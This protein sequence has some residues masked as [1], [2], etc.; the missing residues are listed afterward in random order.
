M[1]NKIACLINVRDRPTEL[2]LLL[3]SIRTQTIKDIDIFILDDCSGTPLSNYHFFNC[4][5]TRLKLDGYGIYLKRT[6]FQHGVSRARQAIVDYALSKGDYDYLLR[7]DDDVILE[8]DY[9]ERLLKVI[10]AGY[11]I[12]SGVTIPM[13]GPVFKRDPK[14]LNEIVNRVILDKDGNYIMNGD[15]CGYGYTDSII[16]PAHHFRSCALIKKEVHDK[17]KYYPTRLSKHGFREEQIFSYNALMSG[18][19]IGVDTGAI[20]YHQMTQSGGERFPDQRDLSMFNQNILIEFT[21]EHKDKLNKIFTHDNMPSKLALM[22]E[23]NLR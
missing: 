4:I 16:L 15:D 12:A 18:F 1:N 23:T 22:K 7:V 5:I 14:H 13:F 9:I 3:Q 2:A 17:V 11:D 6:D 8:Y 10:D 20:N 21:K 19:K